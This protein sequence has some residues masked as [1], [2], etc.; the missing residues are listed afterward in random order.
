MSNGPAVRESCRSFD[1]VVPC[2]APAEFDV[3]WPGKETKSCTKHK[4]AQERIAAFMGFSL[5]VRPVS[6][7][8]PGGG[9]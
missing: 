3:F 8:I 4:D 6:N 7:S 2:P 9:A 1:G 5:P